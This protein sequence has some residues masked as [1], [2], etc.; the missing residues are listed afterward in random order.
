MVIYMGRLLVEHVFVFG[1]EDIQINIGW[2]DVFF[3]SYLT[4]TF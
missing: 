4:V 1:L 2:S 3:K